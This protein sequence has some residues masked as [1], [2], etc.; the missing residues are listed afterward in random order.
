MAGIVDGEGC[1]TV[2]N[3][4]NFYLKMMDPHAI[5]LVARLYDCAIS[6]VKGIGIHRSPF[7]VR[8]SGPKAV[9]FLRDILPF[10]LVKRRQAA[11]ALEWYDLAPHSVRRTAIAAEIKALKKPLYDNEDSPTG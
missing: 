7:V 3:T 8:F 1:I 2:D 5:S 4:P 10:L 6:R 9:L 11:L